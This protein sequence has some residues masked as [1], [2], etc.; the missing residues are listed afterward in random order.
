VLDADEIRAELSSLS[1]GAGHPKTADK[2]STTAAASAGH[3]R[4]F[5][6][7]DF[8][9]QTSSPSAAPTAHTSTPT[10]Y[11]PIHGP[12]RASPLSTVGCATK[13]H[14]YPCHTISPRTNSNPI[15]TTTAPIQS[16]ARA[17]LLTHPSSSTNSAGYRL[18]YAASTGYPAVVTAPIHGC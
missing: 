10:P 18:K 4:F 14:G 13:N 8:M 15:H 1:T 9:L 2:T 5:K 16:G 6:S 12:S 17:C 11:T 3:I 7:R